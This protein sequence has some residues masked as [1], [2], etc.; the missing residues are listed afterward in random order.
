MKKY[1][2]VVFLLLAAAV[3]CGCGAKT[4]SA[5]TATAAPT[6]QARTK[7]MPEQSPAFEPPAWTGL[8]RWGQRARE[9]LEAELFLVPEHVEGEN[10][11][12]DPIDGMTL[13]F[14]REEYA[15]NIRKAQDMEGEAGPLFQIAAYPCDFNGDGLTDYFEYG[16]WSYD[17]G[18][19]VTIFPLSLWLAQENGGYLKVQTATVTIDCG[20]Q[21]KKLES[22]TAGM[23]D[24]YCTYAQEP[25]QSVYR[26]D[27]QS[28]RYDDLSVW[29]M[30]ALKDFD[31]NGQ[32]VS[33][34]DGMVLVAEKIWKDQPYAAEKNVSDRLL[35]HAEE[36]KN[37]KWLCWGNGPVKMEE[38]YYYRYYTAD[39]FDGAAEDFYLVDPESGEVYRETEDGVEAVEP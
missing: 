17:I 6:P 14:L 38:K 39:I 5:P 10:L 19:P 16:S 1:L 21:I 9:E 35:S 23:P 25:W 30:P 13:D 37:E 32:K 18:L 4:P 24:L 22:E 15:G 36:I 34:R 2:A 33:P 28:G 27:P 7:P 29:V 12:K 26:Y 31:V 8:S 11:L 3:L 20:P